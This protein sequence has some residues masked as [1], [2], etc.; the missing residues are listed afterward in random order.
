MIPRLFP[1]V[2]SV[3]Y[4]GYQRETVCLVKILIPIKGYSINFKYVLLK[5]NFP[6]VQWLTL[7]WADDRC[8]HGLRGLA[9]AWLKVVNTSN[10]LLLDKVYLFTR[11]HF[12]LQKLIGMHVCR[13]LIK[14]S[15]QRKLRDELQ[16]RTFNETLTLC[17]SN[18]Q[19]ISCIVSL[20]VIKP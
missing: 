3:P 5:V 18:M 14:I 1:L 6:Y 17:H 9:A 8:A 13:Q 15:N 16:H 10:T 11:F 4:F 19:C 20:P 2:V 12:L 7:K